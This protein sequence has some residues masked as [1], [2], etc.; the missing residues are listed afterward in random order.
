MTK[1]S[2]L[3]P[4]IFRQHIKQKYSKFVWSAYLHRETIEKVLD[5]EY[6]EQLTAEKLSLVYD[7]G[8]E[9]RRWIKTRERNEALDCQVY[10]L[11]AYAILN[12]IISAFVKAAE[13][14][15]AAKEKPQE[16]KTKPQKKKKR[17]GT[18]WVHEY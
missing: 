8:V 15:L 16:V 10:S 17:K 1:S 6:F 12:P 2:E 7:K 14:Q 3:D 4:I 5:Q 18:G 11:A 9:K 13:E